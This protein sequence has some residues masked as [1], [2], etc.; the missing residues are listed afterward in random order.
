MADGCSSHCH[1]DEP[2]SVSRDGKCIAWWPDAAWEA[3]GNV[4]AA[5][6]EKQL[7]LQRYLSH[8]AGSK[9]RQDA[10]ADWQAACRRQHAAEAALAAAT[11]C[12]PS[13]N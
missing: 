4:G 6:G 8:P 5:L 11:A 12:R 2:C 7:A 3:D 9:E 10:W 13:L 1:P